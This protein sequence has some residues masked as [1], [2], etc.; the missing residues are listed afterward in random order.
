MRQWWSKLRAWMTG[1]AAIDTG[2]AEE[3]RSHVEMET[4]G[5]VE[6]GMPLEAARAAARRHFGN[7]TAVTEHAHDAWTFA[8]FESLL[9]DVRHGFRAMRRSPAFSLVVILTFALGV[10]VNTAIFSVVDEVLIKPLPYPESERLV[11]L[12]EAN[13]KADFS[14][15]W[16]NFNYWRDGNRCFEE[17]AAYQGFGGTL[18]GRGDAVTTVG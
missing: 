11:R 12:R 14:V 7:A 18:T 13:A 17:M 10:G 9:K 15:T 4:E 8:P 5:F 3:V 16:G 6:R 2:L 1:R